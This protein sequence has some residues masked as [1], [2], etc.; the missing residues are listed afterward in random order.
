MIK[1]ENLTINGKAYV[2]TWSDIGMMIQRDG[3]LYEEAIDPAELGRVYTETE[4][5][6]PDTEA[7]EADYLEALE[8]F[9]VNN[10]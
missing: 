4:Q 10:D 9:G 2:R 7:T 6:I 3:A 1:T 5:P 8:R